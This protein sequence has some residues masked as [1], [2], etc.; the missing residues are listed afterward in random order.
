LFCLF[1]SVFCLFGHDDARQRQGVNVKDDK[2]MSSSDDWKKLNNS[3]P[4]ALTV[5]PNQQ[6]RYRQ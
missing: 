3:S 5:Q 6:H 1:A 4:A 2:N